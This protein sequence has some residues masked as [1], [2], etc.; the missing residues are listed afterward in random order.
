MKD[1]MKKRYLKLIDDTILIKSMMLE[2]GV[3]IIGRSQECSFLLDGKEVSRK[4]ASVICDDNT[5]SIIDEK[6]ANGTYVNGKKI[7]RHVLK[8]GDEIS[9]GNFTIIFDA[10][11]GIHGVS[12]HTQIHR[13]GE[14]TQSLVGHLESLDDKIQ[15]REVKKELKIF[16]DKVMKDREKLK[17][18]ANQDK[19]TLLYNRAFFDKA[20]VEWFERARLSRSALS[21]I[22]IDIDFFKK[23]N[24]TFGHA[25]GDE[26]LRVVAQLLRSALRQDD[27]VARY[28]GEE[29]VILCA[30]MSASN[31]HATAESL[32]ILVEGTTPTSV[33][34]P[35]TISAGIATFHEHCQSSRELIMFADHALYQAK[36]SGRNRVI[37]YN[38]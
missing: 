13:T 8:H 25:K 18:Q 14:E 2:Q 21:L 30:G 37:T 38:G 12:D 11:E 9:V 35:V 17:R 31:A 22:F 3:C 27:I 34:I 26:V 1:E 4:H 33:C 15:H 10:G 36:S 24:D 6:S 19:L 29:F 28:G 7:T 5:C 32:R 23:V 16:K 20:V